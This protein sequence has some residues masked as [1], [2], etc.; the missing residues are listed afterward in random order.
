MKR[1]IAAIVALAAAIYFPVAGFGFVNFDDPTYLTAARSQSPAWAFAT[2]HLG[3]FHPLTWLSLM[4]DAQVFALGPGAMHVEN[5]ALHALNGA[6]LFW[7]LWSATGDGWRSAI[8]AA[9]FVAHPLHVE[10]VAWIAER[11]DVLGTFFGLL[12]FGAYGK[13]A[14][15]RS[16][17][18]YLACAGLLVASLLCKATLVTFPLLALLADVWPLRRRA[19]IR[20]KVPLL[21]ISALFGAIAVIAQQRGGAVASLSGIP[22]A[23]RIGNAALACVAYLAKAAWPSSL[24]VVY[25]H[26]ALS[27]QGL[28]WFAAAISALSLCALT[29]LAW[30]R[31]H[32]RAGWLFFLVALLPVIGLVQVGPQAMADRYTYLPLTGVFAAVVW[33]L[34]E[35]RV[36]SGAAVAALAAVAH[37]QVGYWRDS[38]TLFGHA[39][40]VTEDNG[41]A[42]R[43]LGVAYLEQGDHARGIENLRESLRV[44]PGDAWAWMDLGIGLSS[45][46]DDDAAGPAFRRAVELQPADAHVWFNYGVYLARRGDDGGLRE[47][48]ARL[49]SLEPALAA[50]LAAIAAR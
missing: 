39:L 12:A 16:A 9:L 14:R 21:A 40:A 45:A 47:V 25:P 48:Q 42:L 26:P 18:W 37:V 46:G 32:L 5:V 3:N 34:P 23:A 24:A 29:A 2:F 10:S 7:L 17:R 20:E 19:A 22:V 27:P 41:T 15:S 1:A 35:W 31:P 30:P 11:K 38:L 6:L 8:V 13:Y 36:A 44:A 50:Q 4:A 43:N 33:S 49:S 28:P